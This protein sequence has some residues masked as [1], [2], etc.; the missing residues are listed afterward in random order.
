M[1][2]ATS[3]TNPTGLANLIRS[4]QKWLETNVPAVGPGPSFTRA[5][6]YYFTPQIIPPVFPAVTVGEFQY[7]D[8]GSTAYGNETFPGAGAGQQTQHKQAQTMMDINIYSDL[9]ADP[10]ALLALWKIRDRIC[11]ALVRAGESDDVTNIQGVPQ[12][13]VYDYFQTV[14]FDTGVIAWVPVN[15]DNHIIHRYY[16]PTEETPNIH[17][18]QLLVKL[19]WL[20]GIN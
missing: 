6:T 3:F 20:E 16:T 10:N 8:K 18:Y 1:V 5:F 15:E 12:I 2:I 4:F 11:A 7:F 13:T 9:T 17:R 19:N 14:P